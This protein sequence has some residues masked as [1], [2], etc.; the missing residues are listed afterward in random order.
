MERGPGVHLTVAALSCAVATAV[1]AA[2]TLSADA[3]RIEPLPETQWTERV[4]AVFAR[5]RPG[6]PPTNDVKILAHYPE[7]F[8]SVLPFATY[9]STGST[10]PAKDRELLALRAAWLCRSPFVWAQ[11]ESVARRHGIQRRELDRLREG[12]DAKGWNAFESTLLRTVD[13]MFVNSFVTDA[14]WNE[15]T[16]R[17]DR[18]QVL[19]ALFTVSG[20]V[21]WSVVMNSFG[22]EAKSTHSVWQPHASGITTVLR[23]TEAQIRL[24]QPRIPRLEWADVTPADR[25]ILD[26]VHSGQLPSTAATYGH[27]PK[28]YAPRQVFSDYLRANSPLAKTAPSVHEAIIM[29]ITLHNRSPIEWAAHQ[30]FGRQKGM[31]NSQIQGVVDGPRAAVWSPAESVLLEAVDEVQVEATIRDD[32]WKELSSYYDRRQIMD[33]VFTAAGYRLITTGQNV[34]GLQFSGAAPEV[35]PVWPGLASGPSQ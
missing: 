20:S 6:G 34:L 26:P 33:I 2:A 24:P 18:R 31:T 30:R 29:R 17:Y 16:A 19:D 4:R 3:R 27:N 32:T 28:L 9:I 7:L 23:L 8:E 11:H 14:T 13:E 5:T 22:A 15:L 21:M 10:L 35:P 25:A 1:T 12:P